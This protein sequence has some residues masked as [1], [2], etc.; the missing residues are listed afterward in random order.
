MNYRK[1]ST[2][3]YRRSIVSHYDFS[4]TNSSEFGVSQTF[5]ETKGLARLVRKKR[6]E[7][8]LQFLQ[9]NQLAQN[10]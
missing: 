7:K 4:A 1:Q 2:S 8:E 6:S 3:V 10:Y 5:S 9:N